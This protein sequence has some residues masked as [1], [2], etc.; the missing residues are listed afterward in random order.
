MIRRGDTVLVIGGGAAG[1]A[2]GKSFSQRGL[3]YD[4][5]EGQSD[6]GGNWFFGSPA[7]R[8]YRS[9]H[10]ISSRTNSQFGD[11]PMPDGYPEYPNHALFL[12]YL[13]SAARQFEVYGNTTLNTT[14]DQLTPLDGGWQVTL[15]G[16]E[17]R[18]YPDV[19]VATGLLREPSLPDI[20]GTFSGEL[21]HSSRYAEPGILD[22]KSVLVVGG[23]NSGC[24]IAVDSAH[25]ARRT[26][27]STRRGYHYMPKFVC[28]KPTQDWLMEIVSEFSTPQAYWSHVKATFKMAGFDGVDFGLPPPD[29]DIFQAHPI[30]NSNLLYHIGHGDIVAKR[31]V[32]R[33]EGSAVVFA[34]GTREMVD[35]VILATGFETSIPFL[36]PSVLDWKRGIHTFFMNA[37]PPTHGN[38]AFAGYFNIPSGFGNIANTLSRFLANYFLGKRARTRAWQVL[39]QVKRYSD[40]IDI[41]HGQFISTRRHAHELDLWKYIK[42]VNFFNE[43]LETQ[44]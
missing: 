43:R 41:G 22:G 40:E 14:V 28:G 25:H 32:V 26:F 6:L 7:A 1:I 13:R 38:I 36:D 10:L 20:P 35:L 3:S 21:I 19:V 33:F 42:T 2:I 12:D 9:T 34:D 30:M 16:G 17:R 24:D 44:H 11:F 5:I 39:N 27:H 37:L 23:G 15:S 29:H 8:V 4:I 31:D 18:W